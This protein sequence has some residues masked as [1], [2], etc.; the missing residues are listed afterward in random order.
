MVLFDEIMFTVQRTLFFVWIEDFFIFHFCPTCD[1]VI[2]NDNDCNL[3]SIIILIDLA[4]LIAQMNVKV[5]DVGF[6]VY[7]GVTVA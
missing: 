2:E 7:S 6:I 5:G 4:L 1:T 3:V